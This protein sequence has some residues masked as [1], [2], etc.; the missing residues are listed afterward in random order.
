M[1]PTARVVVVMQ[2]PPSCGVTGK[3][4]RELHGGPRAKI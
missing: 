2:V 4:D 1:E 3:A